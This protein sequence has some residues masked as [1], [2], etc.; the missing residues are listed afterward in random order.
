MASAAQ[1]SLLEKEDVSRLMADVR[2]LASQLTE[3]ASDMVSYARGSAP[4][5][6]HSDAVAQI[7]EHIAAAG[8]TLARLARHRSDASPTIR[9]TIDRVSD[10]LDRIARGTAE[11][12][13]HID[14]NPKRLFMAEYSDALEYNCDTVS[15]FAALIGAFVDFG[16]NTR[17][18][19]A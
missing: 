14:D 5:A 13:Q 16:A 10:L 18:R 6:S 9:V 12:I 3:D 4:W 19:S 7:R 8:Q 17:A 2:T 15:Q 1:H 11:L